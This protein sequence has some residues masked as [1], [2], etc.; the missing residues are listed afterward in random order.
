MK[1]YPKYKITF[2]GVLF[3]SMITLMVSKLGHA[4]PSIIERLQSDSTDGHKKELTFLVSQAKKN[5]TAPYTEPALVSFLLTLID[6][7]PYDKENGMQDPLITDHQTQETIASSLAG[8]SLTNDQAMKAIR[9]ITALE[10]EDPELKRFSKSIFKIIAHIKNPTPEFLAK[11]SN[12]ISHHYLRGTADRKVD[13]SLMVFGLDLLVELEKLGPPLKQEEQKSLDE[14]VLNWKTL[15]TEDWEKLQK[16]NGRIAPLLKLFEELSL[17]KIQDELGEVEIQDKLKKRKKELED[18][19]SGL[20][21][22]DRRRKTESNNQTMKVVQNRG[23]EDQEKL[24]QTRELKSEMVYNALLSIKLQRL[25]PDQ[26]NSW[27]DEVI[28]NSNNGKTASLFK[29]RCFPG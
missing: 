8:L 9:L 26:P 27:F 28:K 4:E 14:A 10:I 22:D 20:T 7:P 29:I 3:L 15:K 6:I 16:G 13:P 25:D 18:S 2:R 12:E 5:L 21:G 11:W 17:Q 24:T 19:K 1:N 23:Q